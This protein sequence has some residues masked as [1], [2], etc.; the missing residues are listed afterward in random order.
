MT[1]ISGMGAAGGQG[2]VSQSLSKW[3]WFG[4]L[5]HPADFIPGWVACRPSQMGGACGT[6]LAGRF[7]FPQIVTKAPRREGLSCLRQRS[8]G[9][10]AGRVASRRRDRARPAWSTARSLQ[11]DGGAVA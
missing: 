2:L 6:T 3:R 10:R 7:T 8:A 1:T 11:D 9:R 4:L 5:S